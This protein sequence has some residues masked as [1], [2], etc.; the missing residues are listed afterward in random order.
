M[1][2]IAMMRTEYLNVSTGT[3]RTGATGHGESLTDVESYLLPLDQARGASLHSWGVAG[4]L[5]VGATTGQGG[6]TVTMGTALDAAGHTAVLATSGT[7]IVDPDV[8]PNEIVN[9]PTVTVPAGGLSLP[10]DGLS[11]DRFVTLTWREVLGS[12]VV[13]NA[14]VLLHAPWLRLVPVAGFTHDGTQ[15]VLAKVS[16]DAGGKVTGLT[17]DGRRQAGVPAGRLELRVPRATGGG[18]PVV[19]E[20]PAAE[21]LAR[22]DGGLTLNLLSGGAPRPALS[23]DA[24]TGTA[25]FPFGLQVSST[26]G[27]TYGLSAGADGKL[28]VRDVTGA[29]DRLVVDAAGNVG[30]GIGSGAAKRT[31]H[32]VGT[33]IHSGGPVSGFSFA[34][35]T[36]NDLVETPNAGQRWVWYATGGAARLWSG[37]DRLTITATGEGGGLD[38]PRRMRVRQGGDSSAGIWFRQTTP[39]ADRAFVGMAGD[40]L[41]G[42][43][44]NTGA[45]WGLRMDTTSG[46]VMFSGNFGQP[47][48]P[49]IL[50]LFGSRIGDT[51]GG[52]LFLRSGGGVVAFDGN[53]AIG[54]G[55][56][57]PQR[58]L[59]VEGGTFLNGPVEIRGGMG[60]NGGLEINGGVGINGALRVSGA[61]SKGGGGF[62]IDHPLDP[63][64]KYLSHSFVES[65]EMV[66]LYNGT[67]V[68][69]AQGQAMVALPGY[70]EA[71]NRDYCYQL[72]PIGEMTQAVVAGDRCP[73]GPMGQRPSHRAGN[74]QEQGRARLLPPPPPP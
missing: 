43:W 8:D 40:N 35:R 28:R 5:T 4:G 14:P 26:G 58:R 60:F 48:G 2:D 22:P 59:H 64:N 61:L 19:D 52:V 46:E 44:G 12:G 7:A 51:G 25:Q 13:A 47:S 36:V 11:G 68:T 20:A 27:R 53:D 63:A 1:S 39:D 30:I 38:V 17:A 71:V 67:V 45:G 56:G 57:A 54:I 49:S 65:P 74:R 69:D 62:Q 73:P 55:T 41:V 32:V 9:I 50:S 24:T 66:N 70:F 33:E 3:V 10:T 16:L 29:A 18:A 15:I 37:S 34:D 72:T 23:V 42:F 6:V 21:L 31:L